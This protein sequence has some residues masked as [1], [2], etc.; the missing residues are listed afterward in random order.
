MHGMAVKQ[1]GN[2][3]PGAALVAT[4]SWDLNRDP[5]GDYG[6]PS[7][8]RVSERDSGA[9]EPLA[10]HVWRGASRHRRSRS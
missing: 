7:G 9:S 3:F 6:S 4:A 1:S 8:R 2:V 5:G 10:H